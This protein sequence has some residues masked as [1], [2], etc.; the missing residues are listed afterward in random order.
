MKIRNIAFCLSVIFATPAFADG[1]FIPRF[2]KIATTT[3]E[4]SKKKA[5]SEPKTKQKQKMQDDVDAVPKQKIAPQKSEMSDSIVKPLSQLQNRANA[6]IKQQIES[7]CKDIL[8]LG[9]MSVNTQD[10]WERK[11]NLRR[12]IIF[13]LRVIKN[14]LPGSN[15]R[16]IENIISQL[17]LDVTLEPP[18]KSLPHCKNIVQNLKKLINRL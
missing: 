16:V 9:A 7:C 15:A 4:S 2:F 5:T 6:I 10:E 12:S 14:E 1:H 18:T 3:N 11:L 8:V 17:G 13:E